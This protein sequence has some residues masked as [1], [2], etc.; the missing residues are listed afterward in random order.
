MGEVIDMEDVPRCDVSRCSK[1][2]TVFIRFTNQSG[3]TGYCRWHGRPHVE[4]R[5]GEVI[6]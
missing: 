2:A 3:V 5:T 4:R 6:R 1:A